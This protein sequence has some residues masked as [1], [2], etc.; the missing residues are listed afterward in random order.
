[1]KLFL[2]RPRHVLH[3]M[4]DR[5]RVFL[6]ALSVSEPSERAEGTDRDA[7]VQMN[8]FHVSFQIPNPV[9]I[10]S[11]GCISDIPQEHWQAITQAQSWMA[12]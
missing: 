8:H 11:R 9:I 7:A 12:A 10:T 1:M 3:L 6:L 4:K 5:Q 2:S